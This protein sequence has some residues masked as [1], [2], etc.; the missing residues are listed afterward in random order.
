MFL[1]LWRRLTDLHMEDLICV[2]YVSPATIECMRT[3]MSNTPPKHLLTFA[4][5]RQRLKGMPNPLPP[6]SSRP[7]ILYH[8]TTWLLPLSLVSV[9]SSFTPKFYISHLPP[10]YTVAPHLPFLHCYTLTVK[11]HCFTE[12]SFPLLVLVW[13]I[14]IWE[15]IY[16]IC[17]HAM[18]PTGRHTLMFFC[19]TR[20][21]VTLT[22]QQQIAFKEAF[23]QIQAR[24]IVCIHNSIRENSL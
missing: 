5:L 17:T 4:L 15:N 24:Q 9:T 19:K 7:V 2:H 13:N 10:F 12:R 14:F 1:I 6:F 16:A 18:G 21:S 22:E 3:V 23:L 11:C 20:R 8:I